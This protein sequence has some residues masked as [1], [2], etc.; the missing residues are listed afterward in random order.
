MKCSNAVCSYLDLP[1]NGEETIF[2]NWCWVTEHPHA[3]KM[4][5]V[6][7]VTLY[8]KINLRW[9]NDLNF[10]PKTS[11]VLKTLKKKHKTK[12]S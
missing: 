6:P 2:R 4:K 1:F 5:L 12:A 9:I 3:K 8:S 7:Y 10:R 11:P